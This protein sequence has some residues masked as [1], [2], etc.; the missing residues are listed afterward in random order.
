MSISLRVLVLLRFL[1][2]AA[3]ISLFFF[4][5]IKLKE[6]KIRRVAIT[7]AVY[8]AVAVSYC[9]LLFAYGQELAERLIIPIEIGLCLLLLIICSADKWAVSLFV[10]F[11]Q[12]NLSLG[13]LP[14]AC[15]H[16]GSLRNYL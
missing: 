6:P 7:V 11:T 13:L 16:H 14:F 2:T 8:I 9:V 4:S 12:F 1:Q 3:Y 10:M 5:L 15:M